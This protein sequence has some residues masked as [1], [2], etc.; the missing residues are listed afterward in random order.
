MIIIVKIITL[1]PQSLISVSLIL[2]DFSGC[3]V[4]L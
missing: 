4:V 1:H 2:R 3:A